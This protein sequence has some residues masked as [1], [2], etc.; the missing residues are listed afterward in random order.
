MPELRLRR[1]T[2][3]FGL[4]C[5]NSDSVLAVL[6]QKIVFRTS[7]R[8]ENNKD[9]RLVLTLLLDLILVRHN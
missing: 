1:L 4:A 7:N 6:K 5:V 2:P 9:K 8:H 3:F